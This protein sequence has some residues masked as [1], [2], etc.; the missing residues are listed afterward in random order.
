MCRASAS[1]W[2]IWG[3]RCGPSPPAL[4]WRVWPSLTRATSRPTSSCTVIWRAPSRWTSV[5]TARPFLDGSSN[6]TR[7]VVGSR[8][9]PHWR[10]N[11][12]RLSGGLMKASTRGEDQPKKVECDTIPRRHV[13]QTSLKPQVLIRS[14]V[15]AAL[16]QLCGATAA[17]N[18]CGRSW[19]PWS[20]RAVALLRWLYCRPAQLVS[21]SVLTGEREVVVAPAGPRVRWS[22]RRVHGLRIGHGCH[23][24]LRTGLVVR[25]RHDLDPSSADGQTDLA[26]DHSHPR[27][28]EPSGPSLAA[29]PLRANSL[30]ASWAQD[31]R[32][33]P[34]TRSG[35]TPTFQPQPPDGAE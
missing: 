29:S 11:V 22:W 23:S 33:R 12:S 28:V 6:G 4:T 16:A 1:S 35:A 9:L 3:V 21:P 27:A 2:A 5:L 31:G 30:R 34:I 14:S 26:D 18:G 13:G 25:H 24:R 20:A 32:R 19:T 15:A 17:Q 7:L 8:R 10:A